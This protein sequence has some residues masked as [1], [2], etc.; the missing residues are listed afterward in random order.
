MRAGTL[1]DRVTIQR[2]VRVPATGTTAA[3]GPAA[4]WEDVATVWAELTPKPAG[5]TNTAKGT[6]GGTGYAIRIRYMP[7]ITSRNRIVKGD[8]VF[9]I[10]SVINVGERR[11]EL[12]IETR[13]HQTANG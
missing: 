13:E 5:E 8:R 9:D 3:W 10:T 12:L 1:H 7:D 11:R 6:Q 4:G 2:P